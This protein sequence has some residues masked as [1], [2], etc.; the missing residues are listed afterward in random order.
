MKKLLLIVATIF[1]LQSFS[2]SVGE[3]LITN[4]YD[5]FFRKAYTLNPS[6]P[7]GVLESVAFSQSRFSHLGTNNQ[8]PSCI[9]YPTAYGVM[10]LT[11]NGQGYFRNNLVYVS[12]L[13]G[14]SVSDIKSNPEKNILAYA[15]AFSVL[16]TQM[17]ISGNDIALYQ[18]IFIALSELPLVNDLQN[19]FAMNSHLYQLYWFMSNGEF[20]DFYGFPDY[21]INLKNIFGNNY[22]VLSSN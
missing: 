18:P 3:L 11:E 20:Q 16:Q 9:G 19:D 21:L 2:N 10:G 5:A 13:S 17:S 7:K 15:K 6:I 4:P 14:Y 12:Q 22:D 8:E 1:S